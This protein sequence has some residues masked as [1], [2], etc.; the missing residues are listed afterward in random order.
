M[1][2][3]VGYSSISDLR[4]DWSVVLCYRK[5]LSL[6]PI[7]LVVE[8]VFLPFFISSVG[9]K[10]LL[11]HVE[12]VVPRVSPTRYLVRV[13][14]RVSIRIQCRNYPVVFQEYSQS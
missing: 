9:Q 10:V 12:R 14:Y 3:V 4:G 11:A 13:F 8:F 7:P 2:F 5:R 1:L 6:D